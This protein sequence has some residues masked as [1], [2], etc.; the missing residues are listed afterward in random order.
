MNC[1]ADET[2]LS[3]LLSSMVRS[4]MSNEKNE[5][6]VEK[7]MASG[8]SIKLFTERIF[9]TSSMSHF[10][11]NGFNP[12]NN[13]PKL[14]VSKVAAQS[15]LKRQCDER[16]AREQ[17]RWREIDK[18]L[19]SLTSRIQ[20]AQLGMI[21]DHD[22]KGF[23]RGKK[24]SKVSEG[25]GEIEIT[26][27]LSTRLKTIESLTDDEATESSSGEEMERDETT[28]NRGR[29]R[30]VTAKSQWEQQKA[31]LRARWGILR[32]RV[33]EVERKV[34]A[35]S[36][37][38]PKQTLSK[39]SEGLVSST[40][41]SAFH[42]PNGVP[43]GDPVARSELL[44]RLYNDD[45]SARTH[46]LVV[47]RRHG[48]VLHTASTLHCHSPSRSHTEEPVDRSYHPD[49]SVVNDLS[50]SL[51]IDDALHSVREH[52]F[53]PSQRMT[54]S[55]KKK[56]DLLALPLKDQKDKAKYNKGRVVYKRNHSLTSP[57]T[58]PTSSRPG[59]PT[60][61]RK[62]HS[63]DFN[64]D[65]FVVPDVPYSPRLE[66][67]EYKEIVTPSWRESSVNPLPT[68]SGSDIEDDSD[69][70]VVER[71]MR[72]EMKEKTRF[73]NFLTGG[74]KRRVNAG[75]SKPVNL[76]ATTNGDT[77]K[78]GSK[79]KRLPSVTHQA[80]SPCE[81]NTH[82]V[83]PWP[84]RKFPLCPSDCKDLVNPPPPPLVSEITVSRT[85]ATA[86]GL[87]S[88]STPS[89]TATKSKGGGVGDS[90]THHLPPSSPEWVVNADKIEQFASSAD[91]N[92]F[93]S[94]H[95]VLKLTKRS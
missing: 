7:P 56:Q 52:N 62:K 53:F 30:R 5:M 55:A 6:V 90:T 20:R 51:F 39:Q 70:A 11:S 12:P 46:P 44:T 71:H 60:L 19:V 32:A 75:A 26:R 31:C 64:I 85:E 8:Q 86:M 47:G 17:S 63:T 77:A 94:P 29:Y 23:S 87:L 80:T 4:P 16:L 48:R 91:K 92:S 9:K 34:H 95:L 67:L 78:I 73:H 65:N 72:C 35:I 74:R 43:L 41:E 93:A 66:K 88:P 40:D 59:T 57:L 33:A 3:T 69:K 10:L 36:T 22:T 83:L 61:K 15:S 76:D 18:K 2:G 27:Q 68:C 38:A 28:E 13:P 81:N 45:T 84:P 21:Y 1:K 82:F 49:L 54:S 42:H 24:A 89:P 79:K 37:S 50:A 14:R 25:E 58:S